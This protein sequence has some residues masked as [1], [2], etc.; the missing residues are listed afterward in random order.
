MGCQL[1]K[2]AG[3]P[4]ALAQRLAPEPGDHPDHMHRRC[5]QELLEV[6]ARQPKVST[7]AEIKSAYALREAALHTRPQGILDVEGRR[8]LPSACGLDGLMV[9]LRPDREFAGSRVRQ[10]AR[11]AGGT[12]AA[13]SPIKPDADD[14]IARDIVSRAPVDTSLPL[15]TARLLGAPI[16]D[17]GLQVMGLRGLML[18]AL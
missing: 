9:G 2:V 11:L 12:R 7:P 16:Q 3:F 1:G 15:G 13:G 4:P 8:L 17:K 6:R 18:T 5:R 10:G 14:R